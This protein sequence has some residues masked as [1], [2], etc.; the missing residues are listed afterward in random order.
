MGRCGWGGETLHGGAPAAAGGHVC[1]GSALGEESV[2][3]GQCVTLGDVV[4]SREARDVVGRWEERA[5]S[6]DSG[7]GNGTV[8]LGGAR[9]G[10]RGRRLNTHGGL[11]MTAA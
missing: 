4:G 10:T 1:G 9:M 11:A 2:G 6:S 7:G 3:A 5:V 8:E